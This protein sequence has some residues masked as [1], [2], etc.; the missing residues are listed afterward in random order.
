ML[1]TPCMSFSLQRTCYFFAFVFI[2]NCSAASAAPDS[3]ISDLNETLRR[4]E[5]STIAA[6]QD[7]DHWNMPL[8][9]GDNYVAQH[10]LMRFWLAQDPGFDS[11]ILEPLD[12]VRLRDELIKA[13]LEDGSWQPTLDPALSSGT[14]DATIMNY[15]TLKV[16]GLDPS[17][18]T[19]ERA[20]S[21][22]V[23]HGGIEKA[24]AFSRIFMAL[25]GQ[26]SW[27]SV[28][29]APLF[30]VNPHNPGFMNVEQFPQW[31]RPHIVPIAYLRSMRVHRNL[32]PRFSI[33]ELH[34][35]P[36]DVPEMEPI[37]TDRPGVR[38]VIDQVLNTQSPLGSWGGY[39]ISTLLSSAVL[40]D[41]LLSKEVIPD[42]EQL[43]MAINRGIHFVDKLYLDPSS[44]SSYKGTTCD[45]RYWDT[46]LVLQGLVS[47]DHNFEGA[48]TVAHYLENAQI[49]NG[50]IPFGADFESTPDIDD[51]AE[52]VTTLHLL[53]PTLHA[54]AIEQAV[55]WLN[56]MQN[57]DGGWGAFDRNNTG[58]F[59]LRAF[60]RGLADSATL[61]DPSTPD[62]TGHT[63]EALGA[64]GLTV[65][66]SSVV[67][68]A[69]SYLR[70]TVTDQGTWDGRWGVNYIYGTSAV[71]S[72][73]LRVGI[74]PSDKLIRNAVRWIEMH[75]NPDGGFGESTLSYLDAKTAG[76][77]VSTASQTA[78]ALMA[79]VRAG[80]ASSPHAENAARYLQKTA[81]PDGRWQDQSVVGTGHTGLIYLAYPSYP[82]AFPMIALSEY[83]HTVTVPGNPITP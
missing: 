31:V 68:H 32:G 19:L 17:G 12:E 76:K 15:W 66:N 75:Q 24:S 14:L 42:R 51:T 39:T 37:T 40:D 27:S 45:G 47:F 52:L 49:Y 82:V 10:Y 62:V 8:Y 33:A 73:L 80:Q 79:L 55:H 58:N 6:E 74:S 44:V 69:I 9:M 1:S 30:L 35:R 16:M 29:W 28:P 53:N 23:R 70:S 36:V 56:S 64:I 20:R 7:G 81:S 77:G 25:F 34:A 63:L 26:M 50:G 41:Y 2:L 5:V 61:F 54:K 3:L 60:T 38:N 59:I 43:R 21:F 18:S 65:Q 46:I 83:I 78:W 48:E 71:V 67:R 13:Q 4:A 57:S 22:V 11:K 72:G